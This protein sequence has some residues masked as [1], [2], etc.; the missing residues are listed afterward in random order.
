[1]QGAY[2]AS[3]EREGSHQWAAQLTMKHLKNSTEGHGFLEVIL[4]PIEPEET[5]GHRVKVE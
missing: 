4:R 3:K 1:M 5:K 2:G